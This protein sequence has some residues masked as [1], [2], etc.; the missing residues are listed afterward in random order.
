MQFFLCFVIF[1]IGL[2]FDLLMNKLFKQKG[3]VLA[4]CVL[5]LTTIIIGIYYGFNFNGVYVSTSGPLWMIIAL[6]FFVANEYYG[7]VP[8]LR[9]NF[10]L[11]G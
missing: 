7:R 1:I 2:A 9:M 6:N 11:L 3:L 8:M 5:S 4:T 10:I